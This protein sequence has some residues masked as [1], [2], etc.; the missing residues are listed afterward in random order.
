[1]W[2]FATVACAVQ[3]LA[4]EQPNI[5][6]IE[7]DDLN[8]KYSSFAEKTLVETPVMDSIA[9]SGTYFKNAMCQGMMCGPSRNSLISGL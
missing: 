5:L 3:S 2:L 6:F 1:M 9:K 7:I 8:Y 4:A